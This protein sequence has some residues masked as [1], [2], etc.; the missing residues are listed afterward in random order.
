[1]YEVE[2][3]RHPN[4]D[5]WTLCRNIA[6]STVGKNF[7]HIRVGDA[8]K[9]KMLR[10]EHSPIRTLRFTIKITV[11]YWVSVHFVRHKIGVEHYVSTQR[12][13]RQDR[14]DRNKAPQDEPVTHIMDLDAQALI[15]I[16]R[17]RLCGKA[18]EETRHA[19][20]KI[21]LEVI[22]KNPEFADV[23]V[24]KCVAHGGCNEFTPCGK[25]KS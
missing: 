16:A 8:W 2:I 4:D 3:I 1:M 21:C 24:P 9:S 5:D 22:K 20:R 11:P 19:M 10:S 14:Y 18:A 15:N 6:L 17:M 12:N 23:L 13:D 25:A 7:E